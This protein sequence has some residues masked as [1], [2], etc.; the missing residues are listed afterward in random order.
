MLG[1]DIVCSHSNFPSKFLHFFLDSSIWASHPL[2]I[3]FHPIISQRIKDEKT[4]L[5]C[6][7]MSSFMDPCL[8][9]WKEHNSLSNK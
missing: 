6:L 3:I 2:I 7:L 5:N 9:T 4:P 1:L 8:N